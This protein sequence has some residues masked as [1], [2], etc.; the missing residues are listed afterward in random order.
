MQQGYL[1][2][3]V[4]FESTDYYW[5][6]ENA[7]GIDCSGLPRRSLR[8]A[9]FRYGFSSLNSRALRQGVK[10]WWYDASA[11]ALSEGY[12][13]YTIPLGLRGKIREISYDQLLPGDL[14][15][16]ADGVHVLVYLGG[17]Q[18]IQADPGIGKVATLDG[19]V[20]ENSWFGVPV[21]MHRWKVLSS[22]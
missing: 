19:R 12:R 13:D 17:N 14:A 3:L 16:T 18:W 6:G 8:D 7:R 11:K 9:L 2:R 10:Q 22:E 21:T 15:V 5:G 20:D 1:D 4:N